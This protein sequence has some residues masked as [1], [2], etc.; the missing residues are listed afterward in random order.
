VFRGPISAVRLAT[1]RRTGK[2]VLVCTSAGGGPVILHG[3]IRREFL[4]GPAAAPEL[5]EVLAAFQ[6]RG[7][8]V[9]GSARQPVPEA[10]GQRW[11]R[12]ARALVTTRAQLPSAPA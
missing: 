12:Y 4:L 3:R 10:G 7:G 2:P 9:I 11:R 5:D 8:E 6:A 1:V